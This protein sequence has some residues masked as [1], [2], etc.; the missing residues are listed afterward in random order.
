MA[1]DNPS[2]DLEW[3]PVMLGIRRSS[4]ASAATGFAL[5]FTGSLVVVVAAG[6]TGSGGDSASISQAKGVIRDFL[7]AIKRGDDTAAR[8]MLTQVARAKTEEMGLSIAP[9]VPATA[10]YSIRDGEAI[11]KAGDVVHVS[12]TWTDTDAE[13]FTTTD[14]VIWVTRLDPEGWRV[15]GMAMKVFEDTPPLLLDFEDPADMIAKQRQVAME[16]QRRAKAASK[17]DGV[18]TGAAQPPKAVQ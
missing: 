16:I 7:E 3:S 9:P 12:T 18:R 11:D 8:G 2:S 15:V 13:V 4:L 17:P 1:A 5:A 10:T 6:C 14:E